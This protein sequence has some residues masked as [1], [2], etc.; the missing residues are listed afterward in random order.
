MQMNNYQSQPI[1]EEKL[2]NNTRFDYGSFQLDRTGLHAFNRK[3]DAFEYVC[4]PLFVEKRFQDYQSGTMIM[5]VKFWV[6]GAFVA[7]EIPMSQLSNLGTI[8]AE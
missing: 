6:H 1:S 8:L 5:V 3:E 4:D 2:L 7:K